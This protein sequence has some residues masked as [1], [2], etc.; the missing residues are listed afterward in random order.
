MQGR[1]LLDQR[2]QAART[3]GRNRGHSDGMELTGC[4]R[5][6]ALPRRGGCCC[7]RDVAH[8]S[9]P[10]DVVRRRDRG[11]GR[12]RL[13]DVDATAVA[14]RHRIFGAAD[15]DLARR[16]IRSELISATGQRTTAEFAPLAGLR[17]GGAQ[18]GDPLVAFAD[19]HI[20]DLW[21][22]KGEPTVLAIKP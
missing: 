16:V 9:D 20:F 18:L 22:L 2:N 10:H 15:P 6:T 21:D 14:A 12:E 5:G 19:L 8:S 4:F 13:P 7:F 11:V 3:C 17:L 1:G